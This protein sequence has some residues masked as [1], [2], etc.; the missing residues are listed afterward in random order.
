M[1]LPDDDTPSRV[2]AEWVRGRATVP[3][4]APRRPTALVLGDPSPD[5]ARALDD[6]GVAA[7][8][9]NRFA[10]PGQI[11]TSWPPDGRFGEAWVRMPRAGLEAAMLLHAASARVGDGDSVLLYGAVHDGIRA[12]PKRFPPGAA[13]PRTVLV[14]RRCRVLHA[15]RLA[16]PP[17]QDGLAEWEVSG[18]VDWGAG[19]R[20][21]TF[22]PG[23]FAC[24]RLDPGSGLL[25][26]TIPAAAALP[27]ACR[28]LDF[29][30]GTGILA[31]AAL[32]KAGPGA[33]AQLLE[34]DAISLAAAARN[35]PSALRVL[36][37]GTSAVEGPFD[38]IVSNPPVHAGRR[39]DL[40][41]VGELAD[42]APGLLAGDG[43]LLLVALRKLPVGD[44]LRRRFR[45]VREV[46]GEGPFRVWEASRAARPQ[47]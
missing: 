41:P 22:Y 47:P 30:A 25:A 2:A 31:A 33:T 12:A 39:D 16:P 37:H 4:A 5:L 15:T 29:G 3:S 10:S 13:P 19:E 40:R 38:L 28:V 8:R 7:T 35:V 21:W 18:A 27:A 32:E 44:L 46:A 11:C 42:G 26:R 9:W 43:R 14:K 17:R 36:G 6:S 20:G 45:K 23:V 34:P 24:G 1:T